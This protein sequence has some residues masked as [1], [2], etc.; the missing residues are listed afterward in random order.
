MNQNIDG[1]APSV[2]AGILSRP[3]GTTIAYRRL[4]RKS[5]DGGRPGVVFLHGY[6]SDMTG[7]KALALEAF[8]RDSGYAFL[9]F[10]A[11]G[12]GESSGDVFEGTIGRW[13]ADAVAVLDELTEGPQVLVGSSLGGWL[14]LLG[15]VERRHRVAGLVGIAA[16]PDF[17]EDL[18]WAGM[19]FEQRRQLLETGEV[20]EP[21][22]YEPHKPW[23][24]P[25]GLIE[26]GRNHLLLRDI[27]NLECPVRLIHG[28]QDQDVPWQTAL[29][30]ADSLTSSDVEVLLVKD[31]DHRLSRDRDLAGLC[32]VVAGLL[33]Q[34]EGE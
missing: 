15:G 8:C 13:A 17:T 4:V 14:A 12:H 5:P 11:F 32:R 25:R 22:L 28:Q 10:D 24:I 21:N 23:R 26:D 1:G 9:R 34:V 18:M 3:D 27:V 16:A 31:G 7:G 30:L 29:Q 19:S 20:T 2:G 33:R 6:H